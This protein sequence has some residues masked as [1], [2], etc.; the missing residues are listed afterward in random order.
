LLNRGWLLALLALP[1]SACVAVE[2]D[3]ILGRD[4]A[5]GNSVFAS[6]DP[7]L[8]VGLSP[9]VGATRVFKAPELKAL[10]QR[11]GIP[12]VK[13][14]GDLCF[15]RASSPLTEEQL[16]PVLA[17]ALGRTDF[18]LVDFSRYRVPQGKIEFKPRGLTS[19]GL[20]R[21]RVIYSESRSMPVWAKVKIAGKPPEIP[22]AETREVERG[23]RIEVE[24]RSGAARL[25]FTATAASSGR[26]G[27]SVLVRNPDNGRLFSARVLGKGK[28]LINK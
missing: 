12:I 25:A 6:L 8:A 23:E 21:G 7:K 2:G 16:K 26:D 11:N 1:A 5:T 14:L 28:V 19:S 20:W 18:Q 9:L 15:V 13:P 4:L 27:D 3:R 24:V 22:V 17:E 10:E